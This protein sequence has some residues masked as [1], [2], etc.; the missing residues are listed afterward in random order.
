M[1]C[2]DVVVS[3]SPA[4]Q[5]DAVFR[6]LDM[7]IVNTRADPDALGF[8]IGPQSRAYFRV[9][10][11]KQPAAAADGNGHPQAGE[12]L[13]QLNADHAAANH[14]QRLWQAVERQGRRAGQEG[15]GFQPRN[16]RHRRT[17]AGCEDDLSC[18]QRVAADLQRFARE[19]RL[20][21]DIADTGIGGQQIDIFLLAQIIDQFIF[22]RRKFF[23]GIETDYPANA[24]K[25]VCGSTSWTG[26]SRH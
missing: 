11:R 14:Q 9:H 2:S 4:G 24:G 6:L 1:V 12:H 19:A 7:L 21:L 10:F 23:P 22:G 18:L 8:Q 5:R 20:T 17:C 25:A 26:H 16:C 3:E 15:H 13:P